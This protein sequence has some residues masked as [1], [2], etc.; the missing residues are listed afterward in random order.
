MNNLDEIIE[1]VKLL[2]EKTEGLLGIRITTNKGVTKIENH[3]SISLRDNKDEIILNDEEYQ[4]L[5]KLFSLDLKGDLS[6]WLIW[7][8]KLKS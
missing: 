2:K 7:K 5:K 6:E 8:K 4:K 3:F 1:A